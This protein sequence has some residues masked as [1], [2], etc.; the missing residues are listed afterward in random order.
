LAGAL[1]VPVWLALRKVPNWRWFL[2]RTDSVWYPSM[3][4]FRQQT[5]GDWA[6]VFLEMERELRTALGHKTGTSLLAPK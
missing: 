6:A 4:I 2:H 1:G 3:R 5:D